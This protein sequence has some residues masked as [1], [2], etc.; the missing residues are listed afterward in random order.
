MYIPVSTV[1]IKNDC[2]TLNYFS[3]DIKILLKKLVSEGAT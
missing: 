1:I 2:N 3:D